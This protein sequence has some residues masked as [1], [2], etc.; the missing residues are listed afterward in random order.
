MVSQPDAP[1]HRHYHKYLEYQRYHY[2]S[3]DFVFIFQ[4]VVPVNVKLA[5]NITN[6]WD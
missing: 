2:F 1:R 4:T 3:I 5:L 6:E